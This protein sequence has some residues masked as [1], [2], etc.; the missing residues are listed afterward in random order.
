MIFVTNSDHQ[1]IFAHEFM[2]MHFI[3][4]YNF[5]TKK[6]ELVAIGDKIYCTK[7]Y[8]VLQYTVA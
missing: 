3:I 7:Y 4:N 5:T 1:K 8:L 2:T 6:F